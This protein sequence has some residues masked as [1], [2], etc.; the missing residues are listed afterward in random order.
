MTSHCLRSNVVTVIPRHCAV[1]RTRARRTVNDGA[2]QGVG[3]S[4]A[5]ARYL[6]C[7]PRSTTRIR[8]SGAARPDRVRSHERGYR[9]SRLP[10][11]RLSREDRAAPGPVSGATRRG[12][13]ACRLSATV[14]GGSSAPSGAR[15]Q[16]PR[17]RNRGPAR[18]I[19]RRKRGSYA[20]PDRR[21]PACDDR[22]AV[23]FRPVTEGRCP[24]CRAPRTTSSSD[25]L[26]H[27]ATQHRAG[28]QPQRR[29]NDASAI[30]ECR[31]CFSGNGC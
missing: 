18:S 27:A 13:P 8:C 22:L 11:I 3:P 4:R 24:S 7:R 9:A 30:E 12:L 5:A 25:A 20:F 28:F 19:S 26:T 2:P 1:A 14:P 10:A 17:T 21:R 31:A 15:G 23:R 6:F 29:S 16:C